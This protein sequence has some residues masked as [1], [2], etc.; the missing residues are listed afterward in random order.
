MGWVLIVLELK[1]RFFSLILVYHGFVKHLLTQPPEIS[2]FFNILALVIPEAAMPWYIN[3]V[4]RGNKIAA[5]A[6]GCLL[7]PHFLTDYYQGFLI[8]PGTWS[9]IPHRVAENSLARMISQPETKN[10]S[11]Y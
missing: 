3:T 7:P 4:N 8:L 5:R 10:L 9:L 2:N 1:E 11:T 6:A